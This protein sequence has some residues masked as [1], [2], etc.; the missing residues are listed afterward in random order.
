MDHDVSSSWY[1]RELNPC[2]SL[3]VWT[4]LPL[5]QVYLHCTMGGLKGHSRGC[6]H[7][8]IYDLH[9]TICALP[10]TFEKLFTVPKVWRRAQNSFWNQPQ[11]MLQ[12]WRCI[13]KNIILS[14]KYA[15]ETR[16]TQFLMQFSSTNRSL[17]CLKGLTKFFLWHLFMIPNFT[18]SSLLG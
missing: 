4:F 16:E 18:A 8:L 13:E 15:A 17:S 10:P 7:K 2:R 6:F 3:L 12:L 9:Q 11:F 1:S 5:S 14:E